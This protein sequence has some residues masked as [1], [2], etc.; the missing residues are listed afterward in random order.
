[1]HYQEGK[2]IGQKKKKKKKSEEPHASIC[3]GRLP[4]RGSNTLWCND[5]RRYS[6]GCNL[7]AFPSMIIVIEYKINRKSRQFR[8]V[9]LIRNLAPQ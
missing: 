6:T 9:A 5:T 4:D 1:M 8:D 7:L 3:W 2:V